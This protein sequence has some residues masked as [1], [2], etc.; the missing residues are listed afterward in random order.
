MTVNLK[1]G[2]ARHISFLFHNDTI[3][4]QNLVLL[5]HASTSLVISALTDCL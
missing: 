4:G 1:V 3:S 5:L 2:Q